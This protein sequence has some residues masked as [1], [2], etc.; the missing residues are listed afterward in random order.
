MRRWSAHRRL[1]ALGLGLVAL[2]CQSSLELDRYSFEAST[3]GAGGVSAAGDVPGAA[4]DAAR[5]GEAPGGGN[6]IGAPNA[7]GAAGALGLAGATSAGVDDVSAGGAPPLGGSGGSSNAGAGGAGDGEGTAGNADG[8][9]RRASFDHYTFTRGPASFGVG[10]PGLLA[11]D[12]AEGALVAI[13]AAPTEAGG[14]V[15]LSANGAFT[16]SPPS[17]S[18]W[19]DDSFAYELDGSTESAARVRVTVQP[20]SIDLADVQAGRGNGFAISGADGFY[21]AGRISPAGDVNGDGLGDV[22]LRG[23]TPARNAYV[24]FGKRERTPIHLSD[25]E[26]QRE[27]GF[28]I[29]TTVDFI[30]NVAGGGDVNGDGLDDLLVGVQI[31]FGAGDVYVV[32]GKS[33]REPVDLPL[34]ASQGQGF[35]ITGRTQNSFFGSALAAAGDVNGD[36]LADVVSAAF[37]APGSATTGDQSAAFVIFGKKDTGSISIFDIGAGNGGGFAV[38]GAGVGALRAGDVNGDGLDDILCPTQTETIVA[39]G[40]RDFAALQASDIA[41]GLGGGLALLASGRAAAGAGDVNGDGLDDILLGPSADTFDGEAFV[42][43]GTASSDPIPL[44]ASAGF[45]V[46]SDALAL[47][48]SVSDVGDINR[49]GLDDVFFGTSGNAAT[50]AG[51]VVLGKSDTESIDLDAFDGRLDRGL[52]LT[53]PQPSPDITAPSGL[54]AAPAGDVNAD[55]MPDILVGDPDANEGA[56]AAHVLF[57]WDMTSSVGAREVVLRG[58]PGDDVLPFA[59][60]PLVCAYGGR[61]TDTLRV[62]GAGHTLD[63]TAA[64]SC[65]TDI[66][67]IDLTGTGTNTVILNDAVVR[68][69][70]ENRAGV[71][72]PLARTLVVTGDAG[73]R[74]ILRGV[75]ADYQRLGTNGDHDVYRKAGAFYGLELRSA[76][77][78]SLEP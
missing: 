55:G 26:A 11:N 4:G 68:R 8:V 40:K 48:G 12:A 37:T 69:L 77:A 15:E 24:V 73:D 62:G 13:R 44:T 71:P 78:V 54:I 7:E 60:E 67:V 21:T 39:W 18:F 2:G 30:E 5:S 43:F 33:D 6:T 46:R 9:E 31:I 64:S 52:R 32:F 58:G 35:Q 74:V 34:L 42:I 66:E 75:A 50:H 51:F 10:A 28:V 47:G 22:I 63:L 36:G 61:G 59:G 27:A 1:V 41:S 25:I 29:G 57:G 45:A 49:D 65:F 72:A 20:Q 53:A 19:G 16:Y 38:E 23:P 76:L 17:S 14:R 3:A 70:P 56:G